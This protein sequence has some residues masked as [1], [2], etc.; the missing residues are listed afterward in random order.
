MFEQLIIWYRVFFVWLYGHVGFALAILA[1]SIIT[2]FLMKPIAKVIM[3][4]VKREI[5]YE[6][7]LNPLV[8]EI[9]ASEKSGAEKQ[10]ELAELY[11]QYGYS[12][13][14]EV[15]KV[16]PLFVQLPCLFL[17]YYMLEGATILKGV[18]FLFFNDLGA[19]D[20]LL[21]LGINLL[22]FV[23]TGIN[24]A[25]IY[26]T[27]SFT[28]KDRIQA[29]VVALAFLILLY[30]AGTALMIYWTLNN[31]FTCVK[32]LA[33]EHWSG[34]RLLWG[35]AR[36]LVDGGAWRGVL[37]KFK[38]VQQK[39]FLYAALITFLFSLYSFVLYTNYSVVS[40]G[41]ANVVIPVAM[42]LLTIAT[43]LILGVSHLMNANGRMESKVVGVMLFATGGI[44]LLGLAVMCV[45][46]LMVGTILYGHY[47]AFLKYLFAVGLFVN[48]LGILALKF[49]KD[50][51]KIGVRSICISELIVYT[52]F[53]VSLAIHYMLASPDLGVNVASF[54]LLPCLL[55]LPF[56]ALSGGLVFLMGKEL[57]TRWIIRMLF[58]FFAVYYA[59]PIV[60][61]ENIFPLTRNNLP[62]CYVVMGMALMIFFYA[63]K[64]AARFVHV[65]LLLLS[66]SL[67]IN[68]TLNYLKVTHAQSAPKQIMQDAGNASK[69]KLPNLKDLTVKH[70]YNIYL[71]LYD[72]YPNRMILEHFNLYN[73]QA[74]LAK[75]GFS[76][77]DNSY[78]SGGSTGSSMSDF[79]DT[80]CNS[81]FSWLETLQGNVECMEFLK[82]Q[83]YHLNYILDSMTC[84]RG[85]AKRIGD[86]YFPQLKGSSH[87]SKVIV[88]WGQI[89][90]GYINANADFTMG[91]TE[92]EKRRVK[93][94]RLSMQTGV[95]VFVYAH[96][97]NPGHFYN[98]GHREPEYNR[99]VKLFR[100]KTCNIEREI[101]R[102]LS[103]IKDWDNSIIIFSSD[104]GTYLTGRFDDSPLGLL[105]L[106][107]T[108]LAIKWP[109]GYTPTLDVSFSRNIMLEVLICLTGDKTLA[110]FKHSGKTR[111]G[112]PRWTNV[113][114]GAIDNGII[115]V[116]PAKGRN[117][118]EAAKEELDAL[119][120]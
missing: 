65:F 63:M 9:K 36:W 97:D 32:T 50:S 88:L 45:D 31:F 116:G 22:P 105:D 8:A 27:V 1:T 111:R 16:L 87:L 112:H 29:I 73:P 68:G 113:S 117:L 89:K 95:P 61:A 84:A 94:E 110:R 80:F 99:D 56:F 5:A 59:T 90:G 49:M 67:V 69:E 52:L 40:S 77:Y 85:K 58:V 66:L 91:Y 34:A 98:G 18:S 20:A 6:A 28:R 82:S 114:N 19:P 51:E 3:K 86:F 81:E 33:E 4:W 42:V 53:I 64:K 10:F 72:G 108:Q 93:D 37:F 54:T 30:P 24:F 115:R 44:L 120:W 46:K 60:N 102:D 96:Y 55:T 39:T 48:G 38:S 70:G 76:V 12:P 118:F 7:V 101:E 23:M 57:D 83:G 2:S 92:E 79:F 43:S 17:T 15:R 78:S 21:P 107:G 119:K 14:L 106:Y 41:L 104:H 62:V 47:A 75:R 25:A 26:S 71:L 11:K 13:I 74:Y 100:V 103:L 109:K 35:R